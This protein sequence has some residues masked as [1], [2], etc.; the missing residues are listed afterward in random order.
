MW[1]EKDKQYA[2]M[3]EKDLTLSELVWGE[4]ERV[5]AHSHYKGF[6]SGLCQHRG[7]IFSISAW[8]RNCPVQ[9]LKMAASS[10]NEP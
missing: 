5:K 2:L 6:R 8:E 10:V 1:N 9:N 7:R 3:A 4:R